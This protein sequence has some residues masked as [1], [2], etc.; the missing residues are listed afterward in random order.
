M[1]VKFQKRHYEAVAEVLTKSPTRMD[2]FTGFVALF[3][4]DNPYFDEVKF[5]RAV[6]KPRG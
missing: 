3:K 4:A 1:A 2:V 5:Y 6:W